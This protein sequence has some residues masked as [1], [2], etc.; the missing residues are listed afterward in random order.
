MTT[1]SANNS[2]FK[3]FFEKQKLTG[4]NFIDCIQLRM[5]L[6]IE[7]KL[8]K[9]EKP[10]PPA[11]VDPEGHWKRN[12]PQYL[13]E[14]LK[15]KKNAASGAGGSGMSFWDYALE[16]AARI[17]NMVPTKKV[18]KTP[19]EVWHGQAPKL[20]YLKVWGCEAL[21]K[22]DTLTK[23]EKLEPRSIKCIF[24]EML[25]MKDN[26][27][28]WDL[29]NLPPNGK[30]CGRKW[31]PSRR[32]T[33]WMELCIT[34]IKGSCGEG[35]YSNPRD[36]YEEN[37]SHCEA[38]Y[39]LG[40]KIYRDISRWLIGLYQS[41]YIEK[42]LKRYHMKNSKHRSIPMQEKLRLSKSQGASTPAELKRM[43]N[44]PYASAVGSIMYAVR[45][46]RPNVAFAQN[47]TSRFQVVD[48]KFTP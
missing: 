23:P 46:T 21:V 8:I 11:P 20:S 6:S 43:K 15:K 1:L 39:I 16:T 37:L 13:A 2:V 14:L 42:I 40:I 36:D 10:I 32:K 3:G 38:A 5:V 31:Y 18:E 7:D 17:L 35:L 12:C 24:I 41:A 33:T 28:G 45:C 19:Y 22:Q 4:P 30:T 47:I 48:F 25:I 9:L 29:V 26:E 27:L 44:V 34:P